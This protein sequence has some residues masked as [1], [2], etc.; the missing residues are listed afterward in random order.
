MQTSIHSP[1]PFIWHFSDKLLPDWRCKIMS[2]LIVLQRSTCD[3]LPR[4]ETSEAQKNN[5]RA[6]FLLFGGA[7]ASTL[8][9][10]GYLADVFD[11]KTGQPVFSSSGQLGLDDVAVVSAC[12][13]YAS[14]QVEGCSV[15]MHPDWGSAVYPSVLVSSAPPAIVERVVT[16]VMETTPADCWRGDSWGGSEESDSVRRSLSEYHHSFIGC[17]NFTQ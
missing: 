6:K 13:G 7:I 16:S 9:Q 3:L 12:L 1:T 10:M 4:T 14:T 11:P 8:R 17:G 15:L 2:V 5:L